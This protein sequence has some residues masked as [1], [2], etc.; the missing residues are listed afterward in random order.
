MKKT[1]MIAGLAIAFALGGCQTQQTTDAP[2]KS[3]AQTTYEAALAD[4]KAAQKAAAK[5]KNEW[6]DTGKIIKSAEAA[7]AKGDF[8]A[9]TKLAKKAEGQGHIAVEQ[10]REQANA[11]NPGYLY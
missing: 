3:V 2:A 8:E 11:G 4:A 1:L 10:A 6:R 9:A 5:V 7:A